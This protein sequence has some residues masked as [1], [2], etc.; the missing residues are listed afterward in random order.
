[1]EKSDFHEIGGDCAQNGTFEDGFSIRKFLFQL[2][3]ILYLWSTWKDTWTRK[4]N[5]PR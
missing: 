2:N 5:F 4:T 1:M 3:I